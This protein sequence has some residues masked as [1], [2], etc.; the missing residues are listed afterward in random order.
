MEAGGEWRVVRRRRVGPNRSQSPPV[1]QSKQPIS[2]VFPTS[3]QVDHRIGAEN[4][5][6]GV[7]FFFNNFPE[8][9][10]FQTLERRFKA[11]G[12]VSDIFRPQKR[13]IKGKPFGFVR[14]E[15]CSDRE[16]LL[17]EMNNIW[18]GSFK[19][20]AYFPRFERQQREDSNTGTRTDSGVR[21]GNSNLRATVNGG[22][23]FTIQVPDNKREKGK[24]FVEALGGT[25]NKNDDLP[26][27]EMLG[28]QPNE[29][30]MEWVRNSFTGYVKPEFEWDE[31]EDEINSECENLLS[32]FDEWSKFWFEWIRPWSYVDVCSQRT[33]W[34]KWIGVPLQ[35]WNPRFFEYVGARMGMV[36]KVH[37]KTTSRSRLDV[38]WIQM[39]TGLETLNRV[40][41]CR[42]A[43]AQFKIRIEESVDLMAEGDT[44]FSEVNS[45]CSDESSPEDVEDVDHV[46]PTKA[47]IGDEQDNVSESKSIQKPENSSF[48]PKGAETSSFPPKGADLEDIPEEGPTRN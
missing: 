40:V 7:T 13:D 38:A 29:E 12:K 14:F 23:R 20:R 6:V 44:L 4:N 24:T 3:E 1:R 42:I 26:A 36:L 16:A 31:F 41:E 37:E 35:A 30:E 2:R 48:S 8:G 39:S 22:R 18:F 25:T 28:F 5:D 9:T 43:G 33:V 32:E 21:R 15:E 11:I 34:T 45:D 46:F 17:R 10:W 47:Q 19:L 27:D